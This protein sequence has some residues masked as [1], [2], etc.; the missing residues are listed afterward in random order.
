MNSDRPKV[1]LV[2][3]VWPE[4]CAPGRCSPCSLDRSWFTPESQG[5]ETCLAAQIRR[6]QTSCGYK[7]CPPHLQGTLQFTIK[8]LRELLPCPVLAVSL[9]YKP[10]PSLG[11]NKILPSFISQVQ[12][13]GCH[14]WKA[15]WRAVGNPFHAPLCGMTLKQC[16]PEVFQMQM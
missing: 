1:L 9:I 10:P 16:R 7:S 11:W 5:A 12:Q 8:W 15:P 3:Q 4:H 6:S 14:M 13:Q 2:M